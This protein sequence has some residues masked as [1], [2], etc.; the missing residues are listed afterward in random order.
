MTKIIHGCYAVESCFDVTQHRY[1]GSSE[2][3]SCYVEVLEIK[4][5]PSGKNPVVIYRWEEKL[6]GMIVDFRSVD[7]AIKAFDLFLGERREIIAKFSLGSPKGAMALSLVPEHAPWFFASDRG[8]I[9]GHF[10][11]LPR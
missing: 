7:E 9:K 10:A 3:Y 8:Q 11:I 1:A 4:D 2:D 6:G 5:P